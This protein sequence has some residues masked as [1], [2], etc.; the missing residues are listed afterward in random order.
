M[1][2]IY[3]MRYHA[4]CARYA[5]DVAPDRRATIVIDNNDLEHPVLR[6]IGGRV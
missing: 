6:R 5:A 4:A 1:E 2:Q 3:R